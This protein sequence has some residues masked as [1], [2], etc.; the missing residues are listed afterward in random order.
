MRVHRDCII[1]MKPLDDN[2]GGE[3]IIITVVGSLHF[4]RG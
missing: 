1:P 4:K 3:K 2:N